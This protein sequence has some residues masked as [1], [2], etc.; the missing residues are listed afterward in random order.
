[1]TYLSTLLAPQSIDDVAAEPNV[2]RDFLSDLLRQFSLWR[3]RRTTVS[4][5]IALSNDRLEDIGIRRDDIEFTVDRE[6]DRLRL[7]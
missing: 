5:L 7:R 1:M 3:L 6:L 4:K 2:R